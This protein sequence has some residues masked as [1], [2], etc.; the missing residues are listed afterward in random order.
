MK[1]ISSD[2]ALLAW[3]GIAIVIVLYVVGYDLWAGF[4]NHRTMT[5]QFRVWLG[6]PVAGPIIFALWIA[7]PVGLTYHF[8]VRGR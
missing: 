3:I 8:L 5:A 7:V 6:G 4:T 1:W 2:S